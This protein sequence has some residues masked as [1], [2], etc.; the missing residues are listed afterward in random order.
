MHLESQIEWIYVA[1]TVAL[2]PSSVTIA[3][4]FHS[5]Q[6]VPTKNVIAIGQSQVLGRMSVN[7]ALGRR[8]WQDR[9]LFKASLGYR[10]RPMGMGS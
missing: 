1:S 8:R 5:S 10:V 4:C 9:E 7:S 2:T 6:T 3:N